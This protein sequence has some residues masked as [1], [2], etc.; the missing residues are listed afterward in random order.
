MRLLSMTKSSTANTPRACA[1]SV[2][3]PVEDGQFL[4]LPGLEFGADDR[5]EIAHVLGDPEIGFM[6]RSTPTD[7][8]APRPRYARRSPLNV[9]GEPLLRAARDEVQMAAHAP[10]EFLASREELKFIRRE[11][12]RPTSSS[13]W[14]TR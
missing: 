2:E 13:G 6:K 3:D 10:E 7:R 5:R 11:Q 4:R 9:E 12:A 14:R 8:R 1:G